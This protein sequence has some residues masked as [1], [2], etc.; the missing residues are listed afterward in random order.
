M[1]DKKTGGNPKATIMMD[2]DLATELGMTKDMTPSRS[3]AALATRS[4][5]SATTLRAYTGSTE[6]LGLGD[7]LR[8]MRQAGA[9][10]VGG[11]MGRLERMLTNQAIILDAVFNNLA[12]RSSRQQYLTQM[13]QYLKL[14]LKAQGQCRTTIEAL[15]LL[16]NP[17]PYIRQANIAHGP[18][19]VNNGPVNGKSTGAQPGTQQGY[20]GAGDS[21]KVPNKLLEA[22]HAE[23]LD[24]G[25]QATAGRADPVMA[26][27][28]AVNRAKD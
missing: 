10:V 1:A 20:A 8:E 2:E 28:G 11:E 25:A 4:G 16:K 5:L 14:A 9:E 3:M 24:I 13:E 21:G 22:D 23:R 18:Q 27:V 12:E 15:A 6:E 7:L 19:Q 17:Q 26:T